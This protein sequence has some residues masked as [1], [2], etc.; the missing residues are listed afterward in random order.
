[1]LL[2]S[3]AA[4]IPY[5]IKVL[6]LVLTRLHNSGKAISLGPASGK[7][8]AYWGLEN[9]GFSLYGG[10]LYRASDDWRLCGAPRR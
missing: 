3:I 10:T 5:H 9:L 1:M 6:L 7:A 2:L 8:C 4:S